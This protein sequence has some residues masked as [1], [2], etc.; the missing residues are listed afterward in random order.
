MIHQY[1]CYLSDEWHSP[2][3]F[4][5]HRLAICCMQIHTLL[6]D[7]YSPTSSPGL[8]QLILLDFYD[9][10]YVIFNIST[11]CTRSV[12]RVMLLDALIDATWQLSLIWVRIAH[13]PLLRWLVLWGFTILILNTTFIELST[14]AYLRNSFFPRL[15]LRL[16]LLHLCCRSDQSKPIPKSSA[17]I[18]V[19]CTVPSNNQSSE[20]SSNG[21]KPVFKYLRSRH[22]MFSSSQKLITTR[23][24][25][26]KWCSSKLRRRWPKCSTTCCSAYLDCVNLCP[27]I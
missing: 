20:N 6:F 5:R 8:I 10:P 4:Q 3:T 1:S 18:D 7:I 22:L 25:W 9:M 26:V 2:I 16:N 12:R 19:N 27:G 23:Y 15:I 17:F 11:M 21:N 13:W 24:V 14:T